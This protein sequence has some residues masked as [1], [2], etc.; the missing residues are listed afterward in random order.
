[1]APMM[2]LNPPIHVD[3]IDSWQII[4]TNAGLLSQGL[5]FTAQVWNGTMQD[6]RLLAF[7]RPEQRAAFSNEVAQLAHVTMEHAHQR[8]L[9]LGAAVEGVLLN[10]GNE[11]ETQHAT[12]SQRLV[13]LAIEAGVEPFHHGDAC[14]ATLPVGGHRETWPLRTK[15][16]R[17][18][19]ERLYYNAEGKPPGA[20]AV[21]DAL[22]CWRP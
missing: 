3:A 7:A 14:F 2:A 9:E 12:Q 5:T 4:A 22:G 13:E 8:L 20:Q 18:W 16:F 19:L 6:C 17:R 1:M 10:M 21:Q 15:G 11:A